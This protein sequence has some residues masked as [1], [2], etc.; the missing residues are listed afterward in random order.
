LTCYYDIIYVLSQRT[1]QYKGYLKLSPGTVIFFCGGMQLN[2]KQDSTSIAW[3]TVAMSHCIG[4][5]G[6]PETRG[7]FSP[8]LYRLSRIAR[9]GGVLTAEA[10]GTFRMALMCRVSRL[11]IRD[12]S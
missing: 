4:V 8:Q 10:S 5:S 9:W 3:Q 7:I 11:M 12:F 2:C 6:V 1:V